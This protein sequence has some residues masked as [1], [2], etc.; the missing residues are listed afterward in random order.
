[1]V[2]ILNAVPG[3]W[4]EALSATRERRPLIYAITNFIA[5]SFQANA[6]LAVGGSP[7]MSQCLHEADVL[8]ES[9]EGI[10][11]NTGAPSEDRERLIRKALGVAEKRR[12]PT[13]LDPVGYG[14]SPFRKTLVDGLLQDVRFS[15]IKGNCGEL[16]LLAGEE[17]RMKGVDSEEEHPY[18]V[19]TV[20]SLAVRTGSLICAT[21]ARDLVSGGGAVFSVRGGSPWLGRL[22]G[23]GCVLGA[24]MLTLGAAVGNAASGVLCA[25]VLLRRSAER[26]EK[27][28]NGPGTFQANLLD[29]IYQTQPEDMLHE[30]WRVEEATE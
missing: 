15:T 6:I 10:L 26:A 7:V 29:A 2:G 12:I 25:S 3:E 14:A 8:A 19:R 1:M 4:A 20:R 28:S 13:L 27:L 5:A 17:A 23:G 21:G 24:L 9:A 30:K 18:I 22:T 11:V 16:V